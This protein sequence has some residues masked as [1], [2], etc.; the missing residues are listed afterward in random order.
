MKIIIP[1]GGEDKEIKNEFFKIKPLV[2]LGKETMIE[3][4]VKKFQF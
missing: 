1:L 2:T 4:F 3:T